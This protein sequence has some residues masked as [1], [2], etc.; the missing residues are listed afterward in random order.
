MMN[1]STRFRIVP[2]WLRNLGSARWRGPF[3]ARRRAGL[4]GDVVGAP[5]GTPST[6][7][8]GRLLWLAACGQLLALAPLHAMPLLQHRVTGVVQSFDSQTQTLTLSAVRPG[9]P[10]AF[11]IRPQRTRLREDGQPATLPQ[12]PAAGPIRVYYRT[13][14]GQ[15]VATEVSWRSTTKKS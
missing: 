7:S 9:L 1:P 14:L 8:P 10:T 13:E 2:A 5:I 3:A 12:L 6:R 4:R 15:P 11:V